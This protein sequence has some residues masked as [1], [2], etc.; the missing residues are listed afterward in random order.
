MKA[1]A[2]KPE[3]TNDTR[4]L[5][6][7]IPEARWKRW[8]LVM[9]GWTV[10]ALIS[11]VYFYAWRRIGEQPVL[12]SWPML[13]IAKLSVWYCWGALTVLI[14]KLGRWIP[15]QR[16]HWL[17]WGA[18]HLVL[19]LIIV[20]A[21]MLYYSVAMFVLRSGAETDTSF[22]RMFGILSSWH[23]SFYFLAYWAILG[24]DYAI[25]YYNR[26]RD[27]QF[28]AAELERRLALAQLD[29]LKAQLQ[30]HFLF[31]T[32]HMISSM[33]HKD[34]KAA[35]RMLTKLSDL[36]RLSLKMAPKPETTLREEL[37]ITQVY[38]EIQRS[39]FQDRLN[40]ELDID[41]A[42]HDAA[43]PNFLLQPLVENAIQHGVS[44]TSEQALIRIAA[45]SDN[46][47]LEMLV[48]DNGPG[49]PENWAIEERERIGVG[50]TRERLQQFYGAAHSFELTS[51]ESGGAS[52]RIRIPLK[53]LTTDDIATEGNNERTRQRTN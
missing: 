26:F 41:P 19:S 47:S 5:A 7:Y 1:A 42:L 33:M 49:L 24:I 9:A 16:E 8:A 25:S 40:I 51:R 30:P 43:V 12:W 3:N 48:E 15:F 23:Q 29:T 18:T 36:L 27:R 20:I 22:V 31:N 45:Q 50:N 21:F 6:G 34:T 52:V 39:R 2:T 28:R 46:G 13:I 53:H 4:L 35:D 10:I 37:E 17:R 44:Q 38:L 11:A 32:L 14:I